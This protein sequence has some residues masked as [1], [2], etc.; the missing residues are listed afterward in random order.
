MKVIIQRV[1]DKT[2][3]SINNLV[4]GEFSGPG[5]V[6]LVGWQQSD[7][8]GDLDSIEDWIIERIFKIRIFPDKD[9]KMNLS[10]MDYL[11]SNSL[12]GGILI[13]PQFTL[14]TDL[15]SGFRPSFVKAM[16]PKICS[17]RFRSFVNKVKNRHNELSDSKNIK[18]IFGQ[19]AAEMNLSFT[20]W[21]PVTIPMNKN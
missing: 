11:V 18:M 5:I 8:E 12:S 9:D 16:D 15:K 4:E 10:L 3:I 7:L 19:F 13:V 21:G 14:A 1:K 6:A 17:I 20:N 2:S